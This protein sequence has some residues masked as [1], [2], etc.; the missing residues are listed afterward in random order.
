M[1][2]TLLSFLAAA[3]IS[4]T[5]GMSAHASEIV[6][7]NGDTLSGLSKQHG[8]TV[9]N[10]KEWNGLTS[11]MI[12]VNQK[13][14]INPQTTYQVVAGDSLWSIASQ[15]GVTVDELLQWNQLSGHMIYPNQ[16][17]TIKAAAKASET[18]QSA[19]S[20]GQEEGQQQQQQ[21]QQQQPVQQQEQAQPAEQQQS[22]PTAQSPAQQESKPASGKSMTVTATAYTADCPGCSGVTATGINLK[23]NP[24][25]KVIAVDPSVIPLGTKVYVEGYGYAVAGDTGGAIK[26]NKIDI[27][28][29]SEGAAASWGVRTVNIQILN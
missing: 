28:V 18:V 22:Q 23:S 10:I 3:T 29:P 5:V 6:V 27:H 24:N 15:F 13:L 12:F 26:G 9:N 16:Q 21:Q 4:T 11:D 1:K 2:K 14:T 7:K 25:A 20:V 8:V 17:L 19:A